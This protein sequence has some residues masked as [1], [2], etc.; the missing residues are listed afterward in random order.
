MTKDP[1]AATRES[2][3]F[4]LRLP[5]GMRERV[6]QAAKKKGRSMNAE[7]LSYVEAGLSGVET[8]SLV[9]SIKNIESG[10]AEIKKRLDEK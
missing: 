10:I 5:D 8:A 3:K 6:L 1:K 7:L 2:D 4:N 9:K